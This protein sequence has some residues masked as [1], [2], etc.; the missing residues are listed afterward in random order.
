MSGR[1]NWTHE[2]LSGM[3]PPQWVGRFGRLAT[4]ITI[5]S[6]SLASPT[7]KWLRQFLE[8]YLIFKPPKVF[9]KSHTRA[10][11]LFSSIL[12]LPFFSESQ[13][14]ATSAHLRMVMWTS[15]GHRQTNG[16]TIL[17]RHK[18]KYR[19][20]WYR[21]FKSLEKTNKYNTDKYPADG[22]ERHVVMHLQRYLVSC[23][24]VVWWHTLTIPW[25]IHSQ[26]GVIR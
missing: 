10:S 18:C 20:F 12:M 14:V 6:P 13:I 8:I 9:N 11:S 4:F 25:Y 5:T 26:T 2:T 3:P 22:P 15:G 1:K 7:T 21:R 19:T 24:G 23:S 16:N 17:G